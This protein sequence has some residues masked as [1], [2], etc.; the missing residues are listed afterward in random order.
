MLASLQGYRRFNSEIHLLYDDYVGACRKQPDSAACTD[1]ELRDYACQLRIIP[2]IQAPFWI[3][4]CCKSITNVDDANPFY[5]HDV[6]LLN[7]RYKR[8]YGS[9]GSDL[10]VTDRHK[11]LADRPI[12]LPSFMTA[13]RCS[14]QAHICTMLFWYR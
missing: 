4:T 5:G 8:I 14:L 3:D 11:P 1:K 2:Q 6:T 12:L 10:F 13:Y 7:M 9:Y